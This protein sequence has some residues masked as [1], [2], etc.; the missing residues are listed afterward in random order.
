MSALV[1]SEIATLLQGL[2]R[3]N[4]LTR[5]N[6]EAVMGWADSARLDSDL[7]DLALMGYV[8]VSPSKEGVLQFIATEKGLASSRRGELERLSV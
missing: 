8:E 2:V 7:L 1:K 6:Y 3:H 4:Q 5:E